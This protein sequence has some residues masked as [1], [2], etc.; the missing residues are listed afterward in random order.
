[1]C[2]LNLLAVGTIASGQRLN[3]TPVGRVPNAKP[4]LKSGLSFRTKEI[5]TQT[6]VL[7]AIVTKW[8]HLNKIE[9]IKF[10][11]IDLFLGKCQGILIHLRQ[12]IPQAIGN[13]VSFHTC[14]TCF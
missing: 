9:T 13:T 4:S 6:V 5:D 3:I 11:Q 1:M 14:D 10:C 2:K 8:H 12:V 7:G